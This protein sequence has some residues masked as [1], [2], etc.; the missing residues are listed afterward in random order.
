[1]ATVAVTW[2]VFSRAALAA[3]TPDFTVDTPAAL[4]DLCLAGAP[5]AGAT[6]LP[7]GGNAP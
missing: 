1:V 5:A 3:A 4:V 7:G 2:G 6:S